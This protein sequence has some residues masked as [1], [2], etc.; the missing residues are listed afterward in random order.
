MLGDDADHDLVMDTVTGDLAFGP[1]HMGLSEAEGAER[2]DYA[3]ALVGIESLAACN[4]QHLSLG[5][6]RAV[7]LAGVLAMRPSILALDEPSVHLDAMHR[8]KLIQILQCLTCTRIMASHDLDFLWETCTRIVLLHQG[9]IK[10]Q[11]PCHTLLRDEALLASCDLELPLRLQ[12][13]D[14][15]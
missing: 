13:S 14:K 10:T 7:S 6:K 11:G 1:R 15:Y 3:K 8:R 9:H 4:P 2:V 5:Q 12:K